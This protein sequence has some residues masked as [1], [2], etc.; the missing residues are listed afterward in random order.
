MRSPRHPWRLSLLVVGTAVAGVAPAA[1][2]DAGGALAD[3]SFA[4]GA[5][6]MVAAPAAGYGVEASAVM[7]SGERLD[8]VLETDADGITH[9][10][11]EPVVIGSPA[12]TSATTSSIKSECDDDAY[13]LLSMKWKTPWRWSFQSGSTP[14]GLSTSMAERQ[15]K[16]AVASITRGRNVCGIPDRI[17]A[18]S[19]YL[20][21]T[22]R[23]PGVV[24][25]PNHPDRILNAKV[26]T[27]ASSASVPCRSGTWALP[28][29][30]SRS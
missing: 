19:K 9:R 2:A 16:S 11:P 23:K 1:A 4:L 21:R 26:T 7:A 12:T 3:H 30:H 22:T 24:W 14:S 17:G 27:G 15:L 20:G 10:V 13:H 6:V 18:R 29:P 25:S 5:G 8:L 28:A